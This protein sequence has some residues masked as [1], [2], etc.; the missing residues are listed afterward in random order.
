MLHGMVVVPADYLDDLARAVER[1]Q[2][3]ATESEGR[4]EGGDP[5]CLFDALREVYAASQLLVNPGVARPHRPLVPSPA[6][7]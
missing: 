2:W 7:S 4:A 6:P 3:L 1:L 5:L